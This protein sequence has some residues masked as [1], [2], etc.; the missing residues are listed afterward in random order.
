MIKRNKRRI[1]V[2]LLTASLTSAAVTG[3]QGSSRNGNRIT[4]SEG[5]IPQETNYE[6]CVK[7]ETLKAEGP[8]RA[9]LSPEDCVGW[10]K[11]LEENVV[12]PSF[13][14]AL[15]QFA[16]KSGSAV[17][18]N[19]VGNGNYSPLSL[20]FTL[21][22]AG[23]GAEGETGEQILGSLGMRERK[24]LTEQCRKL[25][26]WYVYQTQM[27]KDQ[28]A[29]FGMKDYQGIIKP[30]NSLWISDQLP[31]HKEYRTLAADWFFAS[32]YGVDFTDPD[33][34]KQMEA[35]I[36]ENISGSM[37]PKLDMEIAQ[38][39][40]LAILN[41]MNFYGGWLDPFQTE[42]TQEDTFTLEDGQQVTVPYLNQTQWLGVFKK[43]E[44]YTISGLFTNNSCRML[45]FLPDADRTVGEF[46]ESPEKLKEAMNVETTDWVQGK[47]V[48][49]VP[50]FGFG[51]SY[52][53]RD[54]LIAM[55]MDQMFGENAQFG[56]I[57]PEPLQL[58]S[59]MQETHIAVDENGIEGAAY[60]TQET[61][62]S[63]ARKR[64]DYE[65]EMILNRPFLFGIQDEMYDVWLFFGVCRNP[66]DGDCN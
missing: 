30:G 22:L 12:S 43:G 9:D 40:M 21:A 19:V 56:G 1:L 35:W 59:V 5:E 36:T 38:E 53:L 11:L 47:V 16:Y 31:I 65:T 26:Q 50:K 48:W 55:G 13:R 61:D 23:C 64:T 15:D 66:A 25:Y 33:I 14:K 62:G 37:P 49:K 45:F 60:T 18:K 17:L 44:G 63:Y 57:S 20:Y 58:S 24:E 54:S 8:V 29:H 34:R 52:Q 4:R 27:E 2:C 46:L 7:G 32:S 3:C 10:E 28:R 39:T 42:M 6:N 51:S 41:T